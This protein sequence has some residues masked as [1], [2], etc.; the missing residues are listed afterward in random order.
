MEQKRVKDEVWQRTPGAKSHFA[1]WKTIINLVQ[2]WDHPVG[3]TPWVRCC[4]QTTHTVFLPAWSHTVSG[5]WIHYQWAG[6]TARHAGT[7]P[8]GFI[9]T[10]IS[11]RDKINTQCCNAARWRTS[12]NNAVPL[13]LHNIGH[14]EGSG[15]PVWPRMF[16]V[17][18]QG[19]VMNGNSFSPS[20]RSKCRERCM[21]I[22][23]ALR[24]N[25]KDEMKRIH[26]HLRLLVSHRAVLCVQL[27]CL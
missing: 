19:G 22:H 6:L 10:P 23:T 11:H 21:Y 25:L 4:L 26:L 15:P 27:T 12:S 16:G 8:P 9:I 2:S 7:P 1:Q 17:Q 3:V 24:L 14:S 20:W 18:I 5:R 13:L